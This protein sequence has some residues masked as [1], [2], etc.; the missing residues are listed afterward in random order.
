M[1]TWAIS[2]QGKQFEFPN[3]PTEWSNPI[4]YSIGS[5]KMD[6]KNE[7]YVDVEIRVRAVKKILMGCRYEIEFVNKDTRGIRFEVKEITSDRKASI[8]LK[9]GD[10]KIVSVDSFTRGCKGIESCGECSS[11]FSLDDIKL[12]D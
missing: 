11:D 4:S 9:A 7:K 5:V 3:G 10:T 8:K 12:L 1:T 2:W 6:K